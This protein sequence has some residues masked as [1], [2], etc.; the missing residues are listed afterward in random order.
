MTTEAL[1]ARYTAGET[2]AEVDSFD[3]QVWA[4]FH[5]DFLRLGGQPT[6]PDA[7]EAGDWAYA[8][9]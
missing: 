2:I 1:Y 6:T 3:Q 5:E 4:S 9:A 8:G 7:T